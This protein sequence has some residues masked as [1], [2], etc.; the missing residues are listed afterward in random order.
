MGVK[1]RSHG[2][3]SYEASIT[4]L[5]IHDRWSCKGLVFPVQLLHVFGMII[6]KL[7]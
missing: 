3:V 7:E 6:P 1:S 4:V 2:P 5:L